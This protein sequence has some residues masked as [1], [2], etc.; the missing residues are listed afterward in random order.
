MLSFN[1]V[2]VTNSLES[3][4]WVQLYCDSELIWESDIAWKYV[5]E[6]AEELANKALTT[7]EIEYVTDDEIADYSA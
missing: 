5:E 3:D 6:V 4:N 7:V 1:Y 2:F